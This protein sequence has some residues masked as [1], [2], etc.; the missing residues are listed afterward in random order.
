MKRLQPELWPVLIVGFLAPVIGGQVSFDALPM[1]DGL[2]GA[3][4]GGPEG[5]NL[6]RALLGSLLALAVSIS[7]ARHRVIQIPKLKLSLLMVALVGIVGISIMNSAFPFVSYSSWLTWVVYALAFFSVV[8]TSGRR[9]GVHALLWSL[10]AG[11]TLT[12]LKGIVEYGTIRGS[13]PGYRI[14]AGWSNPNAVAG[15]LCVLVPLALGLCLASERLESLIAGTCSVMMVLAI[16]LTQSKGGIISLGVAVTV[17]FAVALFWGSKRKTLKPMAAIAIAGVLVLGT[18]L[19]TRAQ[20]G[21]APLDRVLDASSSQE[22]SAGFRTLLW[23]GTLD[24]IQSKPMGYGVGTYRFESARPGLTEQTYHAHQTWLQLAMEASPLALAVI[25][26]LAAGWIASVFGGAKKWP[27]PEAGLRAGVLGAV[28]AGGANAF[29][30]SNLIYLGL[31]T[32]LFLVLGV[33]LQLSSD[34]SIPEYSPKNVRGALILVG[35]VLP[36]LL[37]WHTAT[38][39]YLKSNSLTEAKSGN[40][41]GAKSDV[42]TAMALAPMDGE[43]VFLSS[44][45]A[46]SEDARATILSRAATIAPSTKFLEAYGRSAEKSGRNGEAKVALER[47]L[48]RDPK[49]LQAL[50]I[51]YRLMATEGDLAGAKQ[52]AQDLVNVEQSSYFKTRAIPEIVPL[53][54]YDARVFLADHT[55]SPSAKVKLLEEAVLGYRAYFV[56]TVPMVRRLTA[57]DKNASF[58]GQSLREAEDVAERA[59]TV[60]N[61]LNTLYGSTNIKSSIPR[62]DELSAL[63]NVD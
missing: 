10:T 50:D 49:N 12:A 42:E 53:E 35:C 41:L 31:G 4:L 32:T 40:V 13:E 30:E 5:P 63:F 60:L 37:L 25:V 54:T 57:G 19:S 29:V 52:V 17:L 16:A 27:W 9:L 2:I 33:G 28:V 18:M 38:V 48:D 62:F 15:V 24:L 56:Q 61:T 26:V 59:Q 11:G 22:Q 20:T 3:V 39:E 21:S 34:G 36:C 8:A 46:G 47:A 55:S 58:L 45:F 7:L 6:T 23:K 1:E 51:L 44:A 43:A 14:F